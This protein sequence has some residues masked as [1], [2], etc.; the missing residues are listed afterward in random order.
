[1]NEIIE[2]Y[3]AITAEE[4]QNIMKIKNFIAYQKI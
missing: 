2:V 4:I 3:I 1:M